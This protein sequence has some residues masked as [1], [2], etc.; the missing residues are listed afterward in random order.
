MVE[1]RPERPE[2]VDGIRNV[3]SL[4][5]A[6]G[7]E[8]ALVDRL[9]AGS[10]LQVSM[11][12]VDGD[13]VVAHCAF[14]RV[15]LE[16]GGGPEMFGLGPMGVRPDHQ[17]QGIGSGLIEACLAACRAAGAVAVVCVGHPEYYPRFGFREAGEFGLSCEFPVPEQFFMAI[18]LEDGALADVS[19]RVR[20]SPE[21]GKL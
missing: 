1:Y 13:E 15:G 5:Y 9:R 18:E 11:V 4:A 10:A 7:A 19:G 6:Q 16:A 14:S 3:H 21:F 8:A 17:N 12:A 20:Y 2:D